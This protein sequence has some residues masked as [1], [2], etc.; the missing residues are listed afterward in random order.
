MVADGACP[1]CGGPASG[2][3]P[4]LDCARCGRHVVSQE[5][6]APV[7][8]ELD[9][10]MRARLSGWIFAE[11]AAGAVPRVDLA[12]LE[13]LQEQ[14]PPSLT[15]KAELLLTALGRRLGDYWAEAPRAGVPW[16]LAAISARSEREVSYV[17]DMLEERGEIVP[18][19]EGAIGLSPKGWNRVE[20]LTRRQ[21]AGSQA[22]VAMS[23]DAEMEAVY[24]D[25]IAPA[26]Q[27]AGY[28]P[29]RA[30]VVDHIDNITDRI[31]AEIRKSRFVVADFTGHKGGV[32]FE[33]GY[34]RGRD[35]PVFWCCREE[36][37]GDI[38]FDIRQFNFLFWKT[39][40]EL[41]SRLKDRILA[42]V[43]QGPRAG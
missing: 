1:I 21:G 41:Q 43:G 34:A 36:E 24:H 5:A 15:E 40:E 8:H 18:A 20:E 37:A 27:A 23:F 39:P 22:F 12:V 9:R 30:D 16:M 3:G 2:E 31:I 35:L 19:G 33:A 26:V 17:L 29:V 32:Y 25:A 6:Y 11:N 7:R 13:K 42:V 14:K 4:E 38:H 10:D 28:R